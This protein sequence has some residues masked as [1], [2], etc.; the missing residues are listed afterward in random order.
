MPEV[1]ST[2][3]FRLLRD[4]IEQSCGIALGDEKVYLIETRLAGLLA[5]TG[6]SDYG[7]FYRLAANSA[8]T[9]LRDRIVDAMTTNETLWFR[10]THPF[11]ILREV[12]LPPLV[13]EL[14]SGN[15]FRIRIWSGAAST[16]QE[17][18]SIAIT[19]LEYC[20]L[21]PG[22][23]PEQFEIV[24]VDISP[25]ALFIAKAGRYDASSIARGLP[26]DLRDRYFRRDGNVWTVD[27]AVKALVTLRKFNLQDPLDPLGKFD[28]AF[29]R[30]VAI[31]FSDDFKRRLFA[32]IAR[33]TA[34]DGHLFIS[35]VETLRGLSDAFEP[36]LHANGTYYRCTDP[37]GLP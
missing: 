30:Y 37:G 35:A 31:Y 19:I 24:A 6:C 28:I 7:S 22:I 17:P 4:F 29:L 27:P 13:E 20:R 18:Y 1:I 8:D 2:T 23:R 10:D 33:M 12:L 11:T 25:S 36:L 32:N 3:E 34:P 21:H 15:R 16:G 26:E 14:R 9:R 5:E